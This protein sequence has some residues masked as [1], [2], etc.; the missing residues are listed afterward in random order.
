MIKTILLNVSFG[1]IVLS[2][3]LMLLFWGCFKIGILEKEGMMALV[4]WMLRVPFFLGTVAFLVWK[5]L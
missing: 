4:G 3:V 5:F 2:L 1:G